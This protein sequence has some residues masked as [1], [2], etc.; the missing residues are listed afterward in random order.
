MAFP[1]SLTLITV[2]VRADLLPGGGSTGS[3]RLYHHGLPLTGPAADSIVVYIDE[4][5]TFAADGTGSMQVPATNAVG[6]TPQDFAY[7][8]TV[9]SGSQ[10]RRGTVQLDRATTTVNLADVIQWEGA[11]TPGVTYATVAQL[12]AV[13]TDLDAAE[14]DLTALDARVTV[15]E[16]RHRRLVDVASVLPRAEVTG[17]Q[18]L[19]TGT[20]FATHFQADR[21]A[22]I[23][24]LRT[25]TGGASTVGV[26]AEHAW[27]GILSWDG[28]NYTPVTQSVD[29]PTRWAA[30][31]ATYNT[32]LM[33]PFAMVAG[34]EYAMYLLW[35]GAGQAPSLPGGQIWYADSLL[36]QRMCALING[37]TQQPAAPISGAFF[38]PDSRRFQAHLVPA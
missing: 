34:A 17:P 37:Q 20:L 22:S 11:A 35:I 7:N 12:G 24:S 6:W 28:V 33:T 4:T 27:I 21:T 3:V 10:V 15:L 18:A 2:N 29:D 36:D 31:F 9:R 19:A 16:D 32:L 5:E 30:E 25:Y 13:T 14:A 26:G 1:A 23:A 38:G 8:V